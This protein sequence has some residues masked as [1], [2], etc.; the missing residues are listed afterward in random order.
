[1]TKNKSSANPMLEGGHDDSHED[2]DHDDHDHD[3]ED[4]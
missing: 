3:A 4:L 2:H 1:M